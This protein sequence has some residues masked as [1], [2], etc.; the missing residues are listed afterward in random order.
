MFTCS[1]AYL[2]SFTSDP[3]IFTVL[4]ICSVLFVH[5]MHFTLVCVLTFY[6]LQGM[7]KSDSLTFYCKMR[8]Q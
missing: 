1:L 7:E 4:A 5:L 8:G 2:N 6:K 3:T